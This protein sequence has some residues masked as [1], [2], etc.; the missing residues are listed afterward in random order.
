MMMLD[1]NLINTKSLF[2]SLNRFPEYGPESKK[3]VQMN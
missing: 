1:E 2:G 3:K